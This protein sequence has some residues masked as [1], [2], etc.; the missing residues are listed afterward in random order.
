M[1]TFDLRLGK[2][3]LGSVP[4][5]PGIY[6]VYDA[7]S[8]LI[9]VGK[10]KNLKRRLGQ[11]RNAKRRKKHRKMRKIIEA[12]E[13]ISVQ[14]CESELAAEILETQLIQSCRPR[15]NVVGAFH[16]LYPM[17]G[18]KLENQNFYFCYTTQPEHFGGFNLFG[19]FRSREITGEAFFALVKLLRFVG[20][21]AE[22][23]RKHRIP[24]P[25]Y[26]YV[27]SFR[28]LPSEWYEI[29]QKFWRGDT[30]EA[31]E[32]LVLALVE[33]AAARKKNKEVQD[34]LNQLARF[35]KHE[36]LTLA[37]VTQHLNYL[38]YPVSQ[39]ERDVLFLKY[40]DKKFRGQPC[41]PVS[42]GDRVQIRSN[43]GVPEVAT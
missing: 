32:E 18:M 8:Q 20:H 33:N 29:W 11:Y 43:Q 37:R 26:S 9:Y 31:L 40:R 24:L 13:N 34:C 39:A 19:A 12:A 5:L 23:K 35:W 2:D 15:W 42:V 22:P 6:K 30:R 16:F 25:K 3:F 27:Y 41:I 17:I 14:V 10:A 7:A 38:P 36:A 4:A 21:S 1:N 28:Q